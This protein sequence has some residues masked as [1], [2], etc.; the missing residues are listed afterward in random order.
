MVAVEHLAD[1][2]QDYLSEEAKSRQ[3]SSL[4]HQLVEWQRG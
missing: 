4:D 1:Q 3:V 2:S